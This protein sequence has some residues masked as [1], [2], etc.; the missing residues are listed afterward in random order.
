ML[1][2]RNGSRCQSVLIEL[3]HECKSEMVR[4]K[5]QQETKVKRASIFS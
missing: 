5:K 4:Q 3:L 2:E 1:M